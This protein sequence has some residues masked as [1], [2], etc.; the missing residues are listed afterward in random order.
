[1]GLNLKNKIVDLKA[2]LIESPFGV[3]KA[4]DLIMTIAFELEKYSAFPVFINCELFVNY[5]YGRKNKIDVTRTPCIYLFA[6]V[7]GWLTWL[8]ASPCGTVRTVVQRSYCNNAN[9]K[10]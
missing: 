6:P 4:D 2:F 7:L 10:I 9:A 1:M 5:L 8:G 3:N